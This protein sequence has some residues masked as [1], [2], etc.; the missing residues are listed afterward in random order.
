MSHLAKIQGWF[1]VIAFVALAAAG[2]LLEKIPFVRK[3]AWL[4]AAVVAVVAAFNEIRS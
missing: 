1:A 3:A 4:L 2:I